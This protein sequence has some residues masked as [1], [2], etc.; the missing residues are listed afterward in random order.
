MLPKLISWSDVPIWIGVVCRR[1]SNLVALTPR[2]ISSV[3]F[4]PGTT[5]SGFSLSDSAWRSMLRVFLYHHAVAKPAAKA[6]AAATIPNLN[7]P[8]AWRAGLSDFLEV[9]DSKLYAMIFRPRFKVEPT[10][11]STHKPP[12]RCFE[13]GKDC[14]SLAQLNFDFCIC[15]LPI[16]CYGVYIQ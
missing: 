4:S 2:H 15:F 13:L 8:A 10:V 7:Q 6:D 14:F 5:D 9:I 3:E 11:A 12:F 1:K 16:L